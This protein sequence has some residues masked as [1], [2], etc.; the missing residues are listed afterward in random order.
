MSQTSAVV[1]P[2]ATCIHRILPI[3][4]I[5]AQFVCRIRRPAARPR[6]LDPDLTARLSKDQQAPG[7]PRALILDR[8]RRRPAGGGATRARRGPPSL[9]AD[10]GG[11]GWGPPESRIPSAR[12]RRFGLASCSEGKGELMAEVKLIV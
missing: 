4:G 12:G 8:V 10:G 1:S 2:G 9:R 7:E 5:L 3:L 11:R 6:K